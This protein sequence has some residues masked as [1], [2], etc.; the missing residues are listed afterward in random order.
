M[1]AKRK[2]SLS[3]TLRFFKRREHCFGEDRIRALVPAGRLWGLCAVHV[4]CVWES[5]L[6]FDCG[7]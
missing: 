3:S 5:C 6:D 4:E 7:A 1:A 2:T